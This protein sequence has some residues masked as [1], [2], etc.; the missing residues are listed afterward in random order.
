MALM[1]GVLSAS[2]I[3]LSGD[4]RAE[5]IPLF[6]GSLLPGSGLGPIFS[7]PKIVPIFYGDW[8]MWTG[9]VN[10]AAPI[11][12]F[13]YGFDRWVGGEGSP[14]GADPILRQYGIWSAET[15]GLYFFAGTNTDVGP[16]DVGN[17]IHD[18]Q[19][20]SGLQQADQTTIFLVM[21]NG[22]PSYSGF[23]YNGVCGN[24]SVNADFSVYA[25][26]SL[27][28]CT[29]DDIPSFQ[30]IITH[31]LEE[32]MTD[33]YMDSYSYGWVTHQ[34][35]LGFYTAEGADQCETSVDPPHAF[36]YDYNS[37]PLAFG[38]V[39]NFTN[40]L[41]STNP[42]SVINPSPTDGS[43]PGSDCLTWQTPLTPH[44]SVS[45]RPPYTQLDVVY[46][47]L[48]HGGALTHLDF[49]PD[50]GWLWGEAIDSAPGVIVGPP[51][52]VSPNSGQLDVF[53][54]SLGGPPG[55]QAAPALKHY[56]KAVYQPWVNRSTLGYWG[57][58]PP[59]AVSWGTN[60]IDVVQSASDASILHYWSDDTVSFGGEDFAGMIMGPPVIVS[61]GSNLL[62]VLSYTWTG[63]LQTLSWNAGWS[64]QW[65]NVT[66][67]YF[68]Y[69]VDRISASAWNP[70]AGGGSAGSSLQ[71]YVSGLALNFDTSSS[72]SRHVELSFSRFDVR[73]S[74]ATAASDDGS[75]SFVAWRQNVSDPTVDVD[76]FGNK[77]SNAYHV[78]RWRGNTQ[79]PL[80][81]VGGNFVTP[82]VV[83]YG[84]DGYPEIL[85]VDYQGCLWEMWIDYWSAGGPYAY[86]NRTPACG[87]ILGDGGTNL[88]PWYQPWSGEESGG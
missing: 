66:D 41:P 36:P 42:T 68:G 58:G 29:G 57:S 37:S 12:T 53:V 60:R 59:S 51:S 44:F 14:N 74:A 71:T 20:T 34:S 73:G 21:M 52:V 62:D 43:N 72:W 30:R 22:F 1:A 65:L 80:V 11:L 16:N 17:A 9:A 79:S 64:S 26:V 13:L 56:S 6:W 70:R 8:T 83:I 28:G 15:D 67:I 40:I 55:P 86:S 46:V 63:D 77:I 78:V 82:P 69:P 50:Y 32:A 7:A 48:D 25:E 2:S 54:Q 76:S 3:T 23:E 27:D 49:M 24:H 85:G 75:E 61:R 84:S 88:T 35:Y 19:A 18:W 81:V 5:N 4:A 47:D 10:D 39:Q 38:T 33:P 31:E 87:F 45:K